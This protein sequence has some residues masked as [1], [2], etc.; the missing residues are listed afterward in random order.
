MPWWTDDA[1]R[2]R[3]AAGEHLGDPFAGRARCETRR[4][5][6]AR[7]CPG[8]GVQPAALAG[9][10]L[11]RREVLP[12]VDALELLRRCLARLALDQPAARGTGTRERGRQARRRLG[13]STRL[14]VRGAVGVGEEQDGHGRTLSWTALLPK[15]DVFAWKRFARVLAL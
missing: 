3:H 11:E 6:R 10:P 15:C 4:P 12:R 9:D 1:E 5:Q 2:G 14:D 13:V 8:V 7:A